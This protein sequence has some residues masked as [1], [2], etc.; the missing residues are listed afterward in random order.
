MPKPN[1]QMRANAKRALRLRAQAPA[2][3]KGM[4]A[5]GLQRANQFASG[6]NVS[7]DTVRRTFS[8]L[9]RAKA[10]YKPGS[11]TPGTQAYL[12]WGGNAGLSWARRILKK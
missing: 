1:Q 3:R 8:F 10:Y 4:T 11:N 7:L 5:V 2:S 6:K 9:S 12:G